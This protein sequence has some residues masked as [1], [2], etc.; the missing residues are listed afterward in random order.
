MG[1]S[2]QC[3]VFYPLKKKKEKQEKKGG[4]KY[5]RL[6]L[7]QR[8][9]KILQT[10]LFF[11]SS[12]SS[13]PLPLWCYQHLI[14]PVLHNT[15]VVRIWRLTQDSGLSSNDGP[16][17]FVVTLPVITRFF[18]YFSQSAIRCVTHVRPTWQRPLGQ[19]PWPHDGCWRSRNRATSRPACVCV[20]VIVC[21]VYTTHNCLDVRACKA[22][23]RG[24]RDETASV[25]R[26]T[27]LFFL[28]SLSF[29]FSRKWI[30]EPPQLPRAAG[31]SRWYEQ[32]HAGEIATTHEL[33]H[34]QP[35]TWP[36]RAHPPRCQ[37][38]H[39]LHREYS[40]APSHLLP[41]STSPPAS[42][43]RGVAGVFLCPFLSSLQLHIGFRDDDVS[44]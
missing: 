12:S 8:L 42:V 37:E 39:A 36:P 5:G 6:D 44:F 41:P 2:I 34:E 10:A 31:V 14:P 4:G 7:R 40:L 9:A 15:T 26:K 27:G 3:P 13:F 23:A 19:K 29:H 17:S 24:M 25:E 32:E 20:C 28:P 1:R 16:L 35:Q 11:S 43:G 38:Q 30:R 21:P 33:G 18:F 22:P